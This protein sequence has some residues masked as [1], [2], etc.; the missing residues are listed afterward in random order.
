MASPAMIEVPVGERGAARLLAAF[1]AV[2]LF[3]LAMPGTLIGVGNLLLI[4]LQ[5]APQAPPEAWIQAHGQAQIFGWVGSFMLGV[6]LV[7][8]PRLRGGALASLPAAWG[9]W[10][11]WTGGVTLRW[12]TGVSD[13]PAHPYFVASAVLELAA[14]ILALALI[15]RG[16]RERGAAAFGSVLGYAGFCGLGMTL[17][18]NLRATLQA[19]PGTVV[20]PPLLD[21]EWVELAVWA[22]ILPLAVNYS[23]LILGG[24]LG[25]RPPR[26]ARSRL[27]IFDLLALLVAAL[28]V[29]VLL[30][31]FAAA[32]V[33]ALALAI[34]GVWALR[35]LEPPAQPAQVAGVYRGYPVFIRMAYGWLLLGAALG[36]VAH[37]APQWPGL[38]GASRHAVTVGFVATLIFSAGPRLLPRL[39]G[40]RRLFSSSLMAVSL[41]VLTLGCALRVFSEAA[42]YGTPAAWTWS[43]LPLSAYLE[44][45]AVLVFVANLGLTL[46][47][48][49]AYAPMS[50]AVAT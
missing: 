12:L 27:G 16:Q 42:A 28:T 8:L 50:D 7:I 9:V 18:V 48:R 20:Y 13:V 41:W 10:L 49:P 21:R 32:D 25:W 29:A 15:L 26:A 19:A 39:L 14:W 23:A 38:G 22:F 3:F 45:T 34:L 24:V 30:G 2:G 1:V 33:L 35:V 37:L 40:E 43:W 36:V 4:A 44:L 47:R 11:L 17:L 6:S 46:V 31:A 5:R